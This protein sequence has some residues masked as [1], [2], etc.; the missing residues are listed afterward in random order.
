MDKTTD[1][2]ILNI[3]QNA[4]K[5]KEKRLTVNSAMQDVEEW[6]SLG[7]LSILVALDK[8]FDGKI[9]GI[10]ELASADSIQKILQILKDNSLI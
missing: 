2:T 7:H 5:L 3:I 4:L 6:D 1:E 9:G 8:F 10:K